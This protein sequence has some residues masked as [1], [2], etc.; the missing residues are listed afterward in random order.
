[1]ISNALT[2]DSIITVEQTGRNSVLTKPSISVAFPLSPTDSQLINDMQT[3]LYELEGVGLAAP[4]VNYNKAIIAIYIPE[5]AMLL[6]NNAKIKPMQIYI[7][8]KYE[9]LSNTKE[10]DFEGCYSVESTYGKVLRYQTIKVT[11][12]D[13]HGV[14]HTEIASDFYA[15]VLQHEIDHVNGLLITDRLTPDCIQGTF[16]EMLKSR[17]KELPKDK[18]ELFDRLIEK[19]S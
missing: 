1:M 4:Q 17:R 3:L 2:K 16:P 13:I 7:N 9:A 8:P 15:R 14:V 6:R 5:S 12:Q 19:K 11:Y 18:R 10:T